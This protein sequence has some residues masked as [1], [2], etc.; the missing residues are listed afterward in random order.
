M[1]IT[2]LPFVILELLIRNLSSSCDSGIIIIAGAD[3]CFQFE[4]RLTIKSIC[5]CVT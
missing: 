4:C 1:I 5:C 3:S 2:F